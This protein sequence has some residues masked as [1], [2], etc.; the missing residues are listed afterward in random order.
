MYYL[1]SFLGNKY[2]TTFFFQLLLLLLNK[3]NIDY[4]ATYLT[5]LLR[6]KQIH[7]RSQFLLSERHSSVHYICIDI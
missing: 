2:S 3:L 1:E 6:F 5:Q 4:L 7:H